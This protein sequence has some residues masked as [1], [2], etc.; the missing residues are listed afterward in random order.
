MPEIILPQWLIDLVLWFGALFTPA[1]WKAMALAVIITL[2]ATH[3]LKLAWRLAPWTRGGGST[4]VNLFAVV[5][6]FVVIFFVWPRGG[7]AAWWLIGW[8]AGPL[9]SAVFKLFFAILKAYL[10]ALALAL[11]MDR[12]RNES[13]IPPTGVAERRKR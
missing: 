12:R 6:G 2:A 11:N 3:V 1:E 10:P 7:A 4:L 9:A 13:G 8:V 5:I